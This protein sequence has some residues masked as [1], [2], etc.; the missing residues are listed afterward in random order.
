LSNRQHGH[1][2]SGCLEVRR[3]WPGCRPDP[4]CR[5]AW[6]QTQRSV[7]LCEKLAQSDVASRDQRGLPSLGLFY[8]FYPGFHAISRFS[9]RTPPA[10][11]GVE[12]RFD[13]GQDDGLL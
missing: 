7:A 11:V 12:F 13:E 10:G 4:S 2:A 6:H 8:R 1:D 5:F 9:S 3:P